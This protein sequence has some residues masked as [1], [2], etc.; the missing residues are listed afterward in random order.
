MRHLLGRRRRKVKSG[1]GVL[2]RLPSA[3]KLKLC[4]LSRHYSSLMKDIPVIRI[5]VFNEEP[6]PNQC[7]PEVGYLQNSGLFLLVQ[8]LLE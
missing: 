6:A 5:I 2:A 3:I 1:H 7:C 8:L 4:L